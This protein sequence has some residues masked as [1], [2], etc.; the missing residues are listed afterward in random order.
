MVHRPDNGSSM[1][2][3]NVGLLQRDYSPLYPRRLS[4]RLNIVVSFMLYVQA[5]YHC[6]LGI[7]RLSETRPASEEKNSVANL[8]KLHTYPCSFVKIYTNAYWCS[9]C[10][11]LAN[12]TC[13]KLEL[14]CSS[15]PLRI[16]STEATWTAIVTSTFPPSAKRL[17]WDLVHRSEILCSLSLWTQLEWRINRGVQYDTFGAKVHSILHSVVILKLAGLRS[18]W[19]C[20]G[21]GWLGGYLNLK[22]KAVSLHATKA[23]GWEDV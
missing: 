12:I 1:Q 16:H 2:L 23:L 6:D 20:V 14:L 8:V 15:T 9:Q 19:G 11:S 5:K 7:K 13:S 10:F 3:W 21:T 18:N 4:P 22:L 17:S